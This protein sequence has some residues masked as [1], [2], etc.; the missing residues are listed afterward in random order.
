LNKPWL[1]LYHYKKTIEQDN[2]LALLTES[3]LIKRSQE[4][5][6]HAFG[7]IVNRYKKRAYFS[8][9]GF[10]H[11]HERAMD[12]SQ[13][14]FVKTWQAIKKI[15]ASRNFFTWYYT[16]LK[17]TCLNEIRKIS[18]SA[19]PYSQIASNTLEEIEDRGMDSSGAIEKD[20]LKQTV[21]QAINQLKESEKEILMLREF[22]DFS[23]SEI[24]EILNCPQ[25]T[26]MSRL[27]SAR[28]ALKDKLKKY[29]LDGI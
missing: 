18:T 13:E 9:L 8:A 22:Q 19:K 11:Q 16:I 27:Y 7:I 15:D 23:Y 17:N 24:A 1:F 25:G 26:V 2:R 12:L 20:E 4:G 28:K 10:V 6:K 3:E 14:A 21:W 5:D 29:F